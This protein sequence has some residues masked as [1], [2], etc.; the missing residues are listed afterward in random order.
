M[1][2]AVAFFRMLSTCN[3]VRRE[4]AGVREEFLSSGWEWPLLS[5]GASYSFEHALKLPAIRI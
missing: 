4:S 2:L 5:N 3:G 1:A